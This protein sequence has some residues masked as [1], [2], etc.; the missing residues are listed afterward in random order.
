MRQ[1]RCLT[2]GWGWPGLVASPARILRLAFLAATAP[3]VAYSGHVSAADD[4]G[5]PY[6]IKVKIC[7]IARDFPAVQYDRHD[8]NAAAI[9]A[10]CHVLGLEAIPADITPRSIRGAQSSSAIPRDVAA[11]G[12]CL[13]TLIC[14]VMPGASPQVCE[15]D[16]DLAVSVLA[17]LN[18]R[19][20]R[21]SADAR[22]AAGV[23][24]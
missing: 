20:W 16:H 11:L 15:E 3:P 12:A 9:E 24:W 21:L 23:P 17:T 18:A 8:P 22:A 10:Y 2:G 19:G 14:R 7:G 4:D 5:I 6:G 1:R 13:H